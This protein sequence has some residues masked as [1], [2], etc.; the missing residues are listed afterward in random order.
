[1]TAA[2]TPARTG[3]GGA[4]RAAAGVR[5]FAPVVAG[6]VETALARVDVEAPELASAPWR[7]RAA[8]A[9]F[10]REELCRRLELCDRGTDY[11]DDDVVRLS[12]YFDDMAR[13]G[14]PVML[15]QRL[16]RSVTVGTFGELWSQAEPGDVTDLLRLSQWMARTSGTL[17][18]LLVRTYSQ[19]LDPKRQRAERRTAMAERLLAGLVHDG[20]E[21][22]GAEFR[23]APAYLVVVLGSP[24]PADVESLPPTTL[25]G[26]CEGRTHLLVPVPHTA[27]RAMAWSTVAQWARERGVLATGEVAIGAGAVPA[28]AATARR[29]VTIAQ[30]VGA[31]PG[32]V[33]LRELTLE[34]SLATNREG[35]ERLAAVL[36]PLDAEPRLLTT[37]TTF[38][39]EDLD[40]TRTSSVLYLSRGGLSLRLERVGKLTGLDPR[41]TRGIQVLGA[42]L[43]ARALLTA[44]PAG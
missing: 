41:T 35:L 14:A 15:V 3:N 11:D 6:I 17:E 9:A 25:V 29:L 4:A 30:A 24:M 44:T 32:L 42:A 43:S 40:R 31:A 22:D 34:S 23:V 39:A 26:Q 19:L 13:R 5:R 38:F 28:A 37:L 20:A 33:P 27:A 36:D 10:L 18:R 2:T 7:D 12:Q 21:T 8:E 1:M 16:C